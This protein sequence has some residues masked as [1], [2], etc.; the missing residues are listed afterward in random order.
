MAEKSGSCNKMGEV[1][2]RLDRGE[3]SG[4][5]YASQT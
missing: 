2:K 1:T 5:F 3:D 4:V